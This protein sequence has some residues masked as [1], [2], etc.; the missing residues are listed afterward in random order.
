MSFVPAIAVFR[1]PA[2][3]YYW[4]MRQ[5]IGM[6]R[7]MQA[8]AISWQVY[9]IARET[10]SVEESALL[11]GFVGLTQFLPLLFLSP[12]GGQAADRYDRRRILM[13]SNG[14]RVLVSIWL[15]TLLWRP[16]EQALP[17][18]F[19]AAAMLGVLSA[20]T[21]PASNALFP[22]LVP[23]AELPQAIA[24]NSIAF[25]TSALVGPALAG[26]LFLYGPY[27]VYGVAAAMTCLAVL[28]VALIEAPPHEPVKGARAG[29]MILE[30][31]RY[32]RDSQVVFGAISLDFVVVFFGGAMAL[33]P[34]F[35]RDVLG[36]GET[37]FG[38]LR[39]APAA[40][41][42]VVAV[43]FAAQP[44]ARR[45]GRWMLGAVAVYGVATL[46]FAFSTVFWFSVAALALTGVA[47]M[48]SVY[49]RQSLI[50]LATPDAMRGRVSSVSFI[51]ISAS[52]ELGE[53]ESGVAAR[54]LGPV[55]AVVLGGGVA[56]AAAVLWPRLF[57]KLSRVDLF[58]DA[59][60][61]PPPNAPA[62]SHAAE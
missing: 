27:V 22:R 32:V 29:P 62:Q 8:T 19:G 54:F 11:L 7:E 35:A 57:P 20:F 18:L 23:R 58:E 41:A 25:Q 14:V 50:Q 52:N 42:I 13:I 53:F 15:L 28:S 43:F 40:G 60:V 3:R 5:L 4:G 55:G 9:T 51:F 45:V 47:D 56:L 16:P 30:G 61:E 31:L 33:L 34:V 59:A 48:V 17:G 44:L 49:V 6:S 38:L 21:P 10:R 37:G 1:R 39:A 26:L 46:A 24:W 12:L 2:Y 36:V